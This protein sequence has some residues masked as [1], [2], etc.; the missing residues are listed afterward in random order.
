MYLITKKPYGIL[1]KFD[2]F[3]APSEMM[4]YKSEMKFVLDSLPPK[5]GI[6]M[7]MR[8]CKALPK[9]SQNILNSNP[10]L[11]AAR[12][13]RSVTLVDS[14]ITS[15]QFKRLAVESKVSD[16]K[17]FIDVKKI[18]DWEPVATAWIVQGIHM[19]K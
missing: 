14:A 4:K 15:M 17:K 19:D 5:F 1:I 9:E 10:E 12:L 3:I 7:D 6:V 2:G 8:T 18:P 16:S 13:T 11:I